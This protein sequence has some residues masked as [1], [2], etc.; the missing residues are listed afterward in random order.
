MVLDG[1]KHIH[2]FFQAFETVCDAAD[3]VS[4]KGFQESHFLT[5]LVDSSVYQG[6]LD[7]PSFT[8]QSKMLANV[9]SCT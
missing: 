4:H 3:D 6:S 1:I 8:L 2:R 5:P 9:L 7:R